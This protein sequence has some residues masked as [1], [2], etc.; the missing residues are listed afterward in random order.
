[1]LG[2]ELPFFLDCIIERMYVRIA[3]FVSSGVM[4]SIF[5]RMSDASGLIIWGFG[6]L[7]KK[8][9]GKKESNPDSNP[10]LCGYSS[11]RRSNSVYNLR[12]VCLA[13]CNAQQCTLNITF[14]KG[15]GGGCSSTC[16]QACKNIV[17]LA[18]T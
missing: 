18:A 13:Q 4:P 5:F 15:I 8:N 3:L 12:V 2:K 7:N 10:L 11:S 17:E 6:I 14:P 16:V 1:M 9:D